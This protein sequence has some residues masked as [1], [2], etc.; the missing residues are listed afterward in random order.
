[1]DARVSMGSEFTQGEGLLAQDTRVGVRMADGTKDSGIIGAIVNHGNGEP[2][3]IVLV[4]DYTTEAYAS[5]RMWLVNQIV[6]MTPA[7]AYHPGLG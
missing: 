3:A 7:L 4:D 6:G 5:R 1:M 2:F